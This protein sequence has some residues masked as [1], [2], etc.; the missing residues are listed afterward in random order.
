M[1]KSSSALLFVFLSVFAFFCQAQSNYFS[2]DQFIT[3]VRN[4]HPV[5]IQ[6]EI[7]VKQGENSIQREKGWLDPVIKAS[8]DEKT[9]ESKDYFRLINPSLVVPTWYGIDFKAGY[10]ANTGVFLNPENTVPTDGLLYGGVSVPIGQGLFTDKRRTAIK[11]A[12][13]FAES[14]LI[15]QRKILNDLFFEAIKSYWKWVEAW[16]EYIIY[17]QSVELAKT[18]FEAVKTSFKFG[19]K[20]AIDTLEAFIQ[21]QNR[22]V[23]KQQAFINYRNHTLELSNFLWYENNTPMLIGDN[24]Q[25]PKLQELPFLRYKNIDTITDFIQNSSTQHPDFLLYEFKANLIAIEKA[26]KVENLKP[27]LN[28]NYNF[29]T[30]T[31]GISFSP[32]NYKWGVDFNFPILLRKERAEVK[33]AEL[34]LQDIKLEQNL[35]LLEIQNKIRGYYNEQQFLSEQTVLLRNIVTNYNRLLD[36][37]KQK[38]NTGESSIFLVN[39]RENNL[40]SAQLKLINSIAKYNISVA[41]V[42][43]ASG[44]LYRE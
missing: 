1:R 37:E 10:D 26:L 41:G 19:D 14:T 13:T 4:Y 36:G 28:L 42:Q 5:C 9:F 32:Q 34:K 11:Q 27:K 44:D 43:W 7:L 25:P 2:Q 38:F 20:P 3:I 22:E 21:I 15:E 6:S 16:N 24:L 23:S 8:L 29:L 18:R 30:Q 17:E 35:K 31:Q 12:Q 40:I 39:S 33:L